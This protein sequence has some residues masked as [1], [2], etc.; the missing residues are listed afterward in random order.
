[1]S[2]HPHYFIK[3]FSVLNTFGSTDKLEYLN[4][5]DMTTPRPSNHLKDE[6]L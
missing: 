3:T 5:R 2:V 6:L 1:M 4:L